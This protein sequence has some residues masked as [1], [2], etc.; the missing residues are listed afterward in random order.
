MAAKT[1]E[2][3]AAERLALCFDMFDLGAEMMEQKLRRQHPE[4]S[5]DEIRS[6]YAAWLH[7]RPGAEYGDGEGRPVIRPR[8]RP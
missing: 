6:R 2:R 3:L 8:R 7:E 5:D 4:A 1:F